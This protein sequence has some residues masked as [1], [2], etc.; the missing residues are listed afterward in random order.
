[1]LLPFKKVYIWNEKDCRSLDGKDN[2][3]YHVVYN[4]KVFFT[5][6]K[7]SSVAMEKDRSFLVTS[8]IVKKAK[9]TV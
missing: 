5:S 4:F 3:K 9:I 1:M 7:M 6:I 8:I 2:I